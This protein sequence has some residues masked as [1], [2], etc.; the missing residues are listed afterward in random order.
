MHL[1]K[2]IDLGDITVRDG[3]QAL[4]HCF[5]TESKLRL[6][7]EILLAGFKH[8]E[9]TNFGHPKLMPQFRDAEEMLLR[10]LDSERVGPLLA[11][12]GGAATI[13]AVTINER[14]AERAL[15]FKA[16]HGRGPDVLLQMVSTDPEH[17]RVNSGATLEDYWKMTERCTA[18]AALEGM[19]MCG[20][21]STIWGSPMPGHEQTRLETAVEFSRRYLELG[22]AYVEH[23]DHDG[24]ADPARVFDYFRM[25]LDPERMG[26]FHEPRYHLAHFHTTRGMGL[27]NYLA[28]LQAGVVRFETTLSG[29]G[30][31]PANL[32]DG[33][34]VGGTGAYYH[35]EHL[36]GGLV[37]TE[38]FVVMAESMGISTGINLGRLFEI[39]RLFRDEYLAVSPD[40]RRRLVRNVARVSGLPEARVARLGEEPETDEEIMI[41][42]E[43]VAASSGQPLERARGLAEG[44]LDS[45]RHYLRFGRWC[46]SR[47]ET[48]A[49]GLPPSPHLV[50]RG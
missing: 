8:V 32:M 39:G 5:S 7:E 35:K 31:Q 17:H 6:A 43:N 25:V 45:T 29:V 37:G 38:D 12:N 19:A 34:P 26:R 46:H 24:S 36:L 13:T 47:A 23:A 2:S 30:G 14:A 42:A 9:V 33:V 4:E 28:A 41:A 21:V 11:Q 50:G 10:L 48:L 1:P 16:K 20:T 49:S 40:D 27:A 44:I 18:A 22:A 15:A 3:L